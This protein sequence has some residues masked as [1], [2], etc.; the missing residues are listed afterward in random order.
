[1]RE[2]FRED[3]RVRKRTLA[4]LSAWP[5]QLIEGFRTLLK[6]GVAV[7]VDGIRAR[8]ALPHG[9]AAAV[10]GTMRA[11]GLDR[12]LG[13]PADKRLAPLAIAL[14]ASRLISPH[15]QARHRARAGRR[16]RRL[17]PGP[18][19]RAWRGRRG[20]ALPRP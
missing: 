15:L 8:R 14:I 20:R 3:G 16:H 1:L 12:L 5:T 2:S 17:K 19:P 18:A 7:A 10:L 6:G 9:H 4:N 13:K 11:I